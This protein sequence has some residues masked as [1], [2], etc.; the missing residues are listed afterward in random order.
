MR[1][2]HK[3]VMTGATGVVGS[4]AL[5]ELLSR[6]HP[7]V[8]LGR[9][10]L[11]QPHA[12]LVSSVVDLASVESIAA[13]IPDG[14]EHAI[15]GLGTTMKQAGSKEAFRAVDFDAVVNFGKACKQR[16]VKRFVL[17][18]AIGSN[19]KSSNFYL[20]TKGEAEEALAALGFDQLTLMRP[21]FIDDEG[22]RQDDRLGE[23]LGLPVAKALFTVIGK[24]NKYAPITATTLGKGA[25]T[26][27]FDQA[28]EKVR[29][30][31]G[32]ALFLAGA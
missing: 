2:M 17:V 27:L 25:V 13:A 11:A 10:A 4:K 26:F 24:T 8:A 5:A 1:A 16:G 28:N 18:S 31:E 29:F 21:S 32:K 9:R 7:V 20:R 6:G 19:A 15:C 14:I 22:S 23:K 30:P 3:V 12:Q